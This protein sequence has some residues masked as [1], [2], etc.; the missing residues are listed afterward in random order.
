MRVNTA[1]YQ[2]NS[3]ASPEFARPFTAPPPTLPVGTVDKLEEMDRR[4]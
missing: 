4:I 1:A 3:S 2:R